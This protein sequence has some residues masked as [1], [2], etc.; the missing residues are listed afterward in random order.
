MANTL[1]QLPKKSFI[2]NVSYLFDLRLK[3]NIQN[4]L[5]CTAYNKMKVSIYLQRSCISQY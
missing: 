2:N 5:N 3:N 1:W 4:S